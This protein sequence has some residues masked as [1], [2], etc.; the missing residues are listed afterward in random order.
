MQFLLIDGILCKC[1]EPKSCRGENAV[2]S[3][4][5]WPRLR[6]GVSKTLC[7]SWPQQIDDFSALASDSQRPT[8]REFVIILPFGSTKESASGP[9]LPTHS[10]LHWLPSATNGLRG[11]VYFRLWLFSH[12]LSELPLQNNLCHLHLVQLFPSLKNFFFLLYGF[13]V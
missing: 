10:L 12:V 4:R 9:S 6:S 11:V 3:L 13:E 7:S 5:Q 1:S 8:K 2:T